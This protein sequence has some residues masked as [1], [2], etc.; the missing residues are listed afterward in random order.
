MGAFSPYERAYRMYSHDRKN[1]D[2]RGRGM[3]ETWL[4]NSK[5][6][7]VAG[8]IG[9]T[10][11]VCLMRLLLDG[12]QTVFKAFLFLLLC[13]PV[14]GSVTMGLFCGLSLY[15]DWELLS[16]YRQIEDGHKEKSNE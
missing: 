16:L 8:V 2:S 4:A 9:A 13:L 10:L 11:T 5:R 15:E 7:F 1:G 3:L 14:M 12:D 6:E